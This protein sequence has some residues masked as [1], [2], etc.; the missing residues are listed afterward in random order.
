MTVIYNYKEI[1]MTKNNKISNE[2]LNILLDREIGFVR[3]CDNK[4][5]IMLTFI[6]IFLTFIFSIG[7]LKYI[8]N[9]FIYIFHDEHIE[10]VLLIILFVFGVIFTIIGLFKFILLLYAR[11]KPS[12]HDL[13]IYF[14]DI[15]LN[16]SAAAYEKKILHMTNDQFRSE[17]INQIYINALICTK[18]YKFYNSGLKISMIGIGILL[19][20]VL[21]IK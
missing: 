14:H 6:G 20:F 3:D 10:Y 4:T 11:T 18:K 1:Y 2:E 16:Q 13:K 12:G 17:L 9:I 19:L 15:S 5:S 21:F 8:Y 7:I